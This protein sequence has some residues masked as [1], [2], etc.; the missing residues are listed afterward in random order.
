MTSGIFLCT[1]F[2]FVLIYIIH[3]IICKCNTYVISYIHMYICLRHVTLNH[4]S[5]KMLFQRKYLKKISGN[6]CLRAY[7][8][9]SISIWLGTSPLTVWY[10]ILYLIAS[11]I[12]I[13][14]FTH[15]R[16]D[17]YGGIYTSKPRKSRAERFWG[18]GKKNQK[19]VKIEKSEN[20]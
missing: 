3:Y 15:G 20:G 16:R 18:I 4:K 2:F 9:D 11:L 14:I 17:T 5:L 7:Y 13:F 19:T 12:I 10:K 6:S 1:P 8:P